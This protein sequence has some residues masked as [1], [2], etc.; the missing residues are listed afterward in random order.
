MSY[1]MAGLISSIFFSCSLKVQARDLKFFF[2]FF[3]DK[4]NRL[5]CDGRKIHIHTT[6]TLSKAHGKLKN[7]SCKLHFE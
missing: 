3:K 5:N 7:H 2:Y 1:F 4:L 6:R